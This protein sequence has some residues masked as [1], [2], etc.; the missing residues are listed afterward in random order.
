MNVK[1]FALAGL[2]SL[3]S[4]SDEIDDQIKNDD[5]GSSS[6]LVGADYYNSIKGELI[7]KTTPIDL[8]QE[9]ESAK[10]GEVQRE[11][12]TS[13]QIE[14]LGLDEEK[15]LELYK[16]DDEAVLNPYTR[17]PDGIIINDY[18]AGITGGYNNSD[19]YGTY[20][21]FG[22]AYLE[23]G[24]PSIEEI[25]QGEPEF[26]MSTTWVYNRGNTTDEV[27]KEL[28]YKTSTTANW[29]LSVATGVKTSFKTDL[30]FLQGGIE[31]SLTTTASGGGSKTSEQEVR[32]S[33]S[34]KV[35]PKSKRKIVMIEKIREKRIKYTVPVKIVGGVWTCV[36]D[37]KI[38]FQRASAEKLMNGIENK[39]QTWDVQLK[40][41]SDIEIYA[42]EAIPLD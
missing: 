12:L 21:P 41:N 33:Y 18:K 26:R 28:N 1:I 39:S 15:I 2:L 14:E 3:A 31:F 6:K 42:E 9:R 11:K 37:P 36:T 8:D 29:N 7:Y 40:D 19:P 23:F 32:N 35:P 22:F 4:C 5:L 27:K 30:V 16:N 24:E 25:P 34:A 10:N 13:K 38:G 20:D 17:K